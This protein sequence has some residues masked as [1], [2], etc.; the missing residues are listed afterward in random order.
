MFNRL[1]WK[2]LGNRFGAVALGLGILAV[3]V[4]ALGGP[5]VKCGGEVMRPGDECVQ[6]RKGKTTTRSY[7]EQKTL[8][9]RFRYGAFVVGGALLVGGLTMIGV[10]AVR[11]RAAD[12]PTAQADGPDAPTAQ[13]GA[14]DAA[15]HRAEVAP[16]RR[17]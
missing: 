2:V 4:F 13:A 7:D 15:G 8:D 3:A 12:A 1:I 5:D 17:G 6:V 16:P 9:E 14:P 10:R 11:R